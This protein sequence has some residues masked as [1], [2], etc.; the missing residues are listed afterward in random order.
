MCS[1]P[2]ECDEISLYEINVI[3]R[4]TCVER[5][6]K[7]LHIPKLFRKF[8]SPF[9]VLSKLVSRKVH[10]TRTSCDNMGLGPGFG[11]KKIFPS[12]SLTVRDPLTPLSIT[13][14]LVHLP[15]SYFGIPVI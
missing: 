8:P 10:P 13:V 4:N 12:V 7:G 11:V 1:L 15:G 9:K 14:A 2:H 3:M 5:Q 6:H